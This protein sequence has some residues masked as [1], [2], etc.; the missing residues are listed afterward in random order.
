MAPRT[1]RSPS[2]SA[3][4]RVKIFAGQKKF[5]IKPSAIVPPKIKGGN[6]ITLGPP[7]GL[8]CIANPLCR[9]PS[10]PHL[11]KSSGGPLLCSP[12]IVVRIDVRDKLLQEQ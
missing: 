6:A 10:V 1:T 2:G 7:D 3:T 9:N 11:I 4:L 12:N 5:K 8:S